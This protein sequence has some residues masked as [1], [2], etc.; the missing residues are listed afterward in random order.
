MSFSPLRTDD[1]LP[2]TDI[3]E[4]LSNDRRRLV[5][6]H[7][8][9]HPREVSLRDLAERI[10]EAETNESPPP[11][12]IRNSVYVSLHQS[13]LP[14]L[15]EMGLVDYDVDRK[16]ISLRKPARQANIYMEV[17]TRY[18]ITWSTYY[19][20]L[21]TIAMLTVVLSAVD[22]PLVSMLGPL[23]WAT[24]FLVVVGVSTA[25][26]LWSRRWLFLLE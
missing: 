23:P 19:R 25:Y 4:I 13:H 15:D 5:L 21:G 22:A 3:H 6:E 24:L 11:N 26:Q 14:R 8:R 2:E 9:D 10:A 7:L 17:V 16:T 1:P 12:N 20:T 18:G